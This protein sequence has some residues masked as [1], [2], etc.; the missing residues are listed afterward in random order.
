MPPIKVAAFGGMVPAVD[1]RLLR[2]NSAAWSENTWLYAGRL[3]GFPQKVPVKDLSPDTAKVFRI[4]K[5]TPDA[6]HIDDSIWLEFTNPDTDVVR[7]LVINDVYDRY[8]WASSTGSPRYN[9]R[10]RIANGQ[11]GWLLGVPRPTRPMLSVAGDTGSEVSRAYLVTWVSEY[12][13]EGPA[14]E[15]V[16]ANGKSEA[17][18]TLTLGAPAPEDLGVDRNLA[19]TRIYRTITSS[20]GTTTY[21]L[22]DEIPITQT[23]YDD[24]SLDT[25][26]SGKSSLESMN[27]SPP[28]SDLEGF[29]V[30][31]NGFLAGWRNNEVWFS[32]PYR[33][34]AWPS[35]YTL[36]VDFPVVGLGVTNQTLVVCTQGYPVSISG[37]QPSSM[38]PS[39]SAALEPCLSRGS[40]LSVADGVYYSSPNGLIFA[41]QGVV[42]NV[43]KNLITKD[44]WQ[45]LVGTTTLR[46][47]PL[48]SGYFAFGSME[49]GVFDTDAFDMDAFAKENYVDAYRGVLID[50][51]DERVAFNLLSD[52]TPTTS[53]QN[54]IW[55]GEVLIIQNNKLYRVNTAD[56]KPVRRTF[57]WRSKIFQMPKKNNFGAMKI[58]WEA[59]APKPD[60]CGDIP[61]SGGGPSEFP[62]CPSEHGVVRVYGDG[63]MRLERELP[64][65]GEV[66]KMP[67]GFKADYWQFEFETYV[68]ILSVQIAPSARELAS[69]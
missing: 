59:N 65:S 61:V 18:W 30:T 45:E 28:P 55:S 41:G 23:T 7:A 42:Q 43:T 11:P 36:M 40:I 6:E 2:D 9:T 38:T 29:I 46:A 44:K 19:K 58:Y 31:S 51:T 1:D 27:W 54:D 26:V 5:G 22:V 67:S 35:A 8:Y 15:P 63:V 10:E 17:T 52:P 68:D 32:E 57:L 62:K 66:I 33:P 49:A 47:A 64:A 24:V 21:F 48:G 50:P 4:P 3:S 37:I 12:G 20:S 16:L 34:H 13:E 60:P 69:V 14:S 56:H 39:K 53:V 25:V